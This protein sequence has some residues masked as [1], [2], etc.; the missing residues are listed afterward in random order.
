[1]TRR[2]LTATALVLLGTGLPGSAVLAAP[3][4]PPGERT[5]TVRGDCTP[6]G[7]VVLRQVGD[8]TT[9]TVTV[10]GRGVPDGRWRGEHLLEVG[11]DDTEDTRLSV[12]VREHAFTRSFEVDGAAVG[13]VLRL[14]NP[15]GVVCHAAYSETGSMVV[16]ADDRLSGVVRRSGPRRTVVRAEVACG[17]RQRW[18]L[19]MSWSDEGSG[20]GFGAPPQRCRDG[21]VVLREAVLDPDATLPTAVEVSARRAG[22]RLLRLRYAASSAAPLDVPTRR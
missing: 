2:L 7:R 14:V 3:E 19:E 9:T 11:V 1:M 6:T 4:E 8:G 15:A 12:R 10:K 21:R 5:V 18:S 13:G 17:G 22:G 16:V 20:T